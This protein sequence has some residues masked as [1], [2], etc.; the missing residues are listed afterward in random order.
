MKKLLFIIILTLL[1]VVAA[2]ETV[3]LGNTVR[4]CE[5]QTVTAGLYA[6][7]D[8]VG[9]KITFENAFRRGVY[10]GVLQDV[11]VTDAAAQGVNYELVVFNEDPSG[12][13]FTNDAAL[14]IA[15]AD[16]TKIAV[17]P[18]A[19]TYQTAF[20]DN[21]VSSASNLGRAWKNVGELTHVYA[22]L[23]VRGA[24][25]YAATTDVN[26]CATFVQD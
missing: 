20:S 13:T 7:G 1:P 15:D 21:G 9:G 23:I 16:L 22:G 6:T 10:S 12:T 8:L 25:T 24:P 3:V 26:V 19:V 18:I 11:I 2:A 14:D 17:S 5:A 4:I